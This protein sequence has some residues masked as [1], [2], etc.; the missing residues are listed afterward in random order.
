M[1]SAVQVCWEKFANYWDVEPRYVPITRDEPYLT[2]DGM[3]EQI[4]ENT[5]G[6]V[7]IL[8]VTYTGLNEPIKDL[9]A[10][11]DHLLEQD[12]IDVPL[13]VDGASGAMIAPFLQPDLEW[14]FRLERVHSINASGHKYGLVYPGL[15]WVVWRKK[16]F[17]PEELIFHVDYLGGDMPTFALNFSRPGAQ[18]LLQYYNFLRLGRDGYYRVQKASQDVAKYLSG[19]IDEMDHFELFTDGSDIPVF[20]WTLKPD[21]KKWDLFDLS[22]KLRERGWLVAAYHMPPDMHDVQVMRVVVRNG[23]SHDLADLFLDDLERQVQWLDSLASPTPKPA[24]KSS[25]FHH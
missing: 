18:V 14:D 24:P 1:S 4:N 21:V 5:I 6:V 15:G 19:K 7:G 11:L 13:H 12:G 16:E 17:L 9:A 2:P 22:M 3:L 10:A 23:F 8:G 25:G 20:A